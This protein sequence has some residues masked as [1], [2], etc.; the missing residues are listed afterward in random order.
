MPEAKRRLKVFLSY[1]SQDKPAVRELYQRLRE[2]DWIAPWLDEENL[3]LGQHWTTAIEDA[4]DSADAIIIFLSYNSVQKEGFIQKEL[5]YAWDIWLEK[6]RNVIFLI[7]FRLD[8][9][10]VPRHLRAT[11]WGDY[12]GEKK[13]FTYQALLLSLRERHQQITISEAEERVRVEKE[14]R[15][16][17]ATD[18]GDF[19]IL[20]VDKNTVPILVDKWL[21]EN[22][23]SSDE[24][25]NLESLIALKK[26]QKLSVS[27]VVHSL[28]DEETV[29]KVINTLQD[30]LVSNLPLL[31]EV[32]LV[33]SNSEDRTREIA[34][35]FG[36][37]VYIAQS[38]L[39]NYG[40]RWGRGDALW[41]SLYCTQGDLIIWISAD[42]VNIHPRFVYGLI[43]PLISHPELNFVKGFYLRPQKVGKRIQ[44]GGGEGVSEFTRP[45]L[46]LFYPELSGIVQPLS[47]EFGGR[48]QALEQLPF[49]SGYGVDVGLLIEI[50][51]KFGLSSMAQ[52]DLIERIDHNQPVQALSKMS[53]DIMQAVLRNLEK[54]YGRRILNDANKT[55]KL[56]SYREKRYFLDIEAIIESERPPMIVLEEYRSRQNSKKK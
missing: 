8:N 38:V 17:E 30:F 20:D 42:I 16:Q 11:Q 4:L 37:P 9:C 23:F 2:E 34:S 5:N 6:P 43:G 36:V 55:M 21:A 28:N 22:T 25:K 18:V 47:N 12:F 45:L 44:V 53:F 40:S 7:P 19:P 51:S 31:D 29:G 32:I 54:S 15:D 49:F 41:K 10:E 46:N 56:V 26:I 39:P 14:K 3:R 48:R 27:L 13:E 50:L 24:Y 1:A 52:V 35:Q 33:D